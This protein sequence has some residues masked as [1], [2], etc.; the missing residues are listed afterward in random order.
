M[1]PKISIWY[2][3]NEYEVTDE[4]AGTFGDGVTQ[5]IGSNFI[6]VVLDI[7]LELF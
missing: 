3:N 2:D 4:C 7:L 5:G 1:I 6:P